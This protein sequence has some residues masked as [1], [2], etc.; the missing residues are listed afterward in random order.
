MT[1]N[2]AVLI[3]RVEKYMLMLKTKC[4]GEECLIWG[5]DGMETLWNSESLLKLLFDVMSFI[6]L[7]HIILH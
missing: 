6:C 5:N 4:Y 2:I 1:M 3:I 7:T